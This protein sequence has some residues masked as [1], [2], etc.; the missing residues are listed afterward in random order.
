MAVHRAGQQLRGIPPPPCGEGLGVGVRAVSPSAINP[1]TIRRA[2]ALR[3]NMTEGE[4]KLWSELRDFRRLYGVHVRKQVP[5]GPYIA[6]FAIHSKNLIIE[7]DGEHH[8]TP[9]GMTRDQRRDSWFA[10]QGYK[11]IR[12]TTGEL[13]ESFG[14]CVEEILREAGL[15]E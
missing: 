4:Q 14:G 10:S 6:D 9:E 15:M 3:R 7:V 2:R 11:T 8:F 5:I 12:M 13:S 1:V